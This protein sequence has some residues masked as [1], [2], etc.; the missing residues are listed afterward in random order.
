MADDLQKSLLKT[1]DVTIQTSKMTDEVLKQAMNDFLSGAAEKKGRLTYKQLENKSSGKLES[2]EITDN[3]IRDFLNV[4]KKY[5]VDFALKRDKSTE[6]P[7]YHVFFQSQK[8]DNFNRAFNEYVDKKTN[9]IDQHK[10]SFDRQ[11]LQK[12]AIE[13]SKQPRERADKVRERNMENSL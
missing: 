5:D 6:P 10:A 4:A 9:Q 3:N 8:A 13:I 1:I 7:T 11:K 12:R 2:I